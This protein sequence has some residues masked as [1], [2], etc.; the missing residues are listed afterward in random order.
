MNIKPIT[1]ALNQM[2]CA[3]RTVT[4]QFNASVKT[5]YSAHCILQTKKNKKT[6]YT[7]YLLNTHRK[8]NST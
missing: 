7:C 1:Y 5:V 8:Q 6:C 3:H 4:K 2:I